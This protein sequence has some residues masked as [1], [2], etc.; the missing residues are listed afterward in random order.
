MFCSVNGHLLADVSG[1][2]IGPIFKNQDLHVDSLLMFRGQSSG[3]IFKG[4]DVH[5]DISFFS[6]I[7]TREDGTELSRNVGNKLLINA[8]KHPRRSKTSNIRYSETTVIHGISKTHC[9]LRA[10]R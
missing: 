5:E 8:A 1:Q 4:E 9:G 3:S 7:L 10:C 6:N 2:R